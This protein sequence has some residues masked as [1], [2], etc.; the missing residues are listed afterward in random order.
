MVMVETDLLSALVGDVYDAAL[1][2]AL[3]PDVLRAIAEFVGGPAAA[4]FWKNAGE[5]T[6]D[7]Y[8]DSGGIQPR[9]VQLYFD[10]YIKLDPATAGQF[11]AEVEEPVATADLIPYDEFRETRFYREWAQPQ[12]LVD[13]VG[14]VLDKSATSVAM[15]GVFRHERDGIV[16]DEA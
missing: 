11:F 10:K 13:F 3:W 16:D 14:A 8:Y 2:P 9:Y 6:G 7:V 5:R 4:L 1:D 15:V 12:G